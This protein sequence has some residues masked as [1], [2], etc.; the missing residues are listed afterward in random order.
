MMLEAQRREI[1]RRFIAYW[2]GEKQDRCLISLSAPNGCQPP[3]RPEVELERYWTDPEVVRR[4]YLDGCN[5]NQLFG[6]AL[7][8]FW[9]NLGPGVLAACL[10]SPYKFS[11]NTVWFTPRPDLERMDSF[12][13]LR[14]NRQTGMY[15]AVAK[16]MDYMARNARGD[17]LT[18]MT[19]LGGGL[20]VAAELMGTEELLYCMQDDP[21]RLDALLEAVDREW[22]IAYSEL[23]DLLTP[24][25]QGCSSWLPLWHPGKM[26]PLQCDLS[27]MISPRMFERFA[28]PSLARQ[29][30]QLDDAVYHMD[31]DGEIKHLEMILSI[32]RLS[33]IEWIPVEHDINDPIYYP[34]YQRIQ[35]AGV[36]LILRGIREAHLLSLVEHVD[37]SA[38]FITM[39]AESVQQAQRI[40]DRAACWC[41]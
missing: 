37:P 11:P 40:M 16:L 1:E 26:Y 19:D 14:I 39:N 31:G 12:E 27:V 3:L 15:P 33:A 17:Y 2:N 22:A 21:G 18:A 23:H 24:W 25:Q 9:P 30:A 32:P 41:K 10:G 38:L 8:I 13:E 7:P 28:L 34:L 4:R 35:R 29:A 20:D 5:C 6:E 36:R